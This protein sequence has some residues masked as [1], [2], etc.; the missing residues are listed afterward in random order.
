MFFNIYLILSTNGCSHLDERMIDGMNIG[1]LTG[2]T[3]VKVFTDSAFVSSSYDRTL[4]TNITGY[5]YVT[6]I[7][8]DRFM[9]IRR[10][11]I[12]GIRHRGV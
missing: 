11:G 3:Q 9:D 5:S 1:L 2:F 12:V 4:V 8:L 7:C 10:R 6:Q